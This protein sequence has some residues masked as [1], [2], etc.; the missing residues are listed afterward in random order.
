[1]SPTCNGGTGKPDQETAAAG[2]GERRR[3]RHWGEGDTWRWGVAEVGFEAHCGGGAMAVRLGGGGRRVSRRPRRVR[4]WRPH[5][6]PPC[7]LLPP[8]PSSRLALAASVSLSR[9]L[10]R[11]ACL[12]ACLPQ[13]V[14]LLSLSLSLLVLA[15]LGC[16]FPPVSFEGSSDFFPLLRWLCHAK[17]LAPLYPYIYSI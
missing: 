15:F 5:G 6:R 16:E 13:W 3:A 11:P 17:C 12:P 1:M 8:L 10:G 14:P 7:S 2:S 4:A 9:R